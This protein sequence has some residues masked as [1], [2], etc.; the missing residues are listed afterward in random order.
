MCV[1]DATA[2]TRLNNHCTTQYLVWC[3]SCGIAFTCT[4]TVHNQL[5]IL[6]RADILEKVYLG[7]CN[8]CQGTWATPRGN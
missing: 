8:L 4:P 6:E 1:V 2:S 7:I 5:T 3:V